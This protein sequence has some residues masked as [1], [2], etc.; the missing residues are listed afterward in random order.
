MPVLL[1][2]IQKEITDTKNEIID[3]KNKL[4]FGFLTAENVLDKFEDLKDS[5]NHFS[6]LYDA[7]LS[8]YDNVVDNDKKKN[9]LNEAITNS[10]IL[11]QKVVIRFLISI[12]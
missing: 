2:V 3:N 5:V 4:L 6:S 7:Y 10:Y 1:N 9:E 8:S 11:L 12:L